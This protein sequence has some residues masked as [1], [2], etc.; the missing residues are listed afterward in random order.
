MFIGLQQDLTIPKSVRVLVCTKALLS[1]CK[2]VRLTV[3][4]TVLCSVT[5]YAYRFAPRSY[6]QVGKEVCKPIG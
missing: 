3:C 1:I 5:L 6:C 2:S 4:N